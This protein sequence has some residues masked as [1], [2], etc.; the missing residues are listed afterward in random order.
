MQVGVRTESVFRVSRARSA[1]CAAMFALLL[2]APGTRAQTSDKA[3]A[4]ELFRQGRAL[5]Q[6]QR[7]G[8]ACPK[9][10]ES[11]RLDPSTGTLLNL[12]TCHERQGKLASAWSE[13]SDV[14]TFAQRDGREDRVTYARER[15]AQVEPRLSRLK[16]ELSPAT[17]GTGLE[18]RLDGAIVGR[19]AIGVAVPVDAGA[20]TIG[21]SAPGKQ[22][23]EQSI[24]V[25]IGPGVQAVTVPPLADAPTTTPAQE[26]AAGAAAP[27]PDDDARAG[28]SQRYVA[29][30]LGGVGVVGLTLGT[31][32]G[33]KAIAKNGDSNDQGCSGN[34]CSPEA[35]ALREDAQRA[36]NI[37]TIAFAVGG[38]ALAGGA[39]LYFT[40]PKARP[41][42]HAKAAGRW[43]LAA[44]AS[45]V[46]VG[47]TW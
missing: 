47:V 12:A 38:A 17:D 1:A 30:G 28:N 37:S 46:A 8:E 31:I 6:E 29:Y 34:N 23:W 4:E 43:T 19:P 39:V 10:G 11:Q 24:E 16:I 33:L 21:A 9:L 20:H 45:R 42:A 36:G 3:L 22:H 40:A 35:A 7:Y 44:G 32:F 18:V 41:A 2:A 26:P 15:L 5:M 14:I 13:Y 25:P 27:P